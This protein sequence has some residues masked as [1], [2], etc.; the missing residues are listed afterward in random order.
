MR[1]RSR[2]PHL[3]LALQVVNQRTKVIDA[4]LAQP[5]PSEKVR[6]LIRERAYLYELKHRAADVLLPTG[7]LRPF[8][9]SGTLLMVEGEAPDGRCQYHLPVALFTAYVADAAAGREAPPTWRGQAGHLVAAAHCG[10]WCSGPD[11]RHCTWRG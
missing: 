4:L 10:G 2:P 1:G 6:A 5:M 7:W 11:A 3:I 8:G 9:V